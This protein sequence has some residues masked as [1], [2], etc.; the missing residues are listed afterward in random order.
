MERVYELERMW[1]ERK[2]FSSKQYWF[3]ATETE[4]PPVFGD[5]YLAL[6][7]QIFHWMNEKNKKNNSMILDD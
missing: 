1:E 4:H 6:D 2:K 3:S 5:L 7:K